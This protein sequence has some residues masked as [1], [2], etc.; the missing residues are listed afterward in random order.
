MK[1]GLA[2]SGGGIRAA[3]FHLGVLHRLA[4]EE[5]LKSITQL[6]TV[7]GGSLAAAAIFANSKMQWP[8]SAYYRGRLYPALRHLLATTDLF[9][10]KAIGWAGLLRFNHR[11]L[12][13]RA[14]VLALLLAE[15]WGVDGAIR[16]LPD[17]PAWWINTTCFETGKNFQFAKREMGDWQF[18]RHY[19][20]HS[21]SP[22]PRRHRRLFHMP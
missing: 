6:S 7:S 21:C 9:S 19:G 18:G 11:L 3:V 1:I 10:I 12:S 4:D 2:L 13:H 16:D 17:H 15:R 14:Q 22:K 5:L 20:R 8:S